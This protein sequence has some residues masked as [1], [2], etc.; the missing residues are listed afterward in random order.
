MS[1]K[2][3]LGIVSAADDREAAELTF[4]SV[5]LSVP[6]SLLSGAIL[7]LA[8]RNSWFGY[9]DLPRYAP[10]LMVPALFLMGLYTALRYWAVR[11]GE[12]GLISKTTVGQHASRAFLQTGVGLI[13]ST[14]MVLM[15]GEVVGR[16]VGISPL[17]RR[18]W[19]KIRIDLRQA[20]IAGLFKTLKA[21]KKLAVYSL[22]STFIDTLVA[23]L[24][25]PIVVSIYG[26]EAGGYFALVQKVLAVPLGLI[27]ASV[28]D[29]FHSS[30][31]VCAREHPESMRSLFD[32]TSIWLFVIGLIPGL[33]LIAGGKEAFQAIF[34]R[35]W[36]MAGTIGAICAPWFLTQFVVS[37]L[38]RLVF[39]LRGQE[40]KLIYD[41]AILTGMWAVAS[42]SARWNLTLIQTAWSFSI[43]NTVAYLIYYFVLQK[44]ILLAVRRSQTPADMN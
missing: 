23:N 31:A 5:L 43:V 21:N 19:R 6:L 17:L 41:V 33:S 13:R 24:P 38:S 27:S 15:I 16:L 37:P 36:G 12:F 7:Y 42:L 4:A 11:T 44:I 34:G 28:A 14:S 39:V 20:S 3:E 22:P 29:T 25:I 2:Y 8:I 9:G 30:L 18:E 35:Q 1:L 40:S 10:A 26:L 32:R